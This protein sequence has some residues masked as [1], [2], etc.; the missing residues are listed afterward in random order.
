[1][2]PRL[3]PPVATLLTALIA[4][5]VMAHAQQGNAA[6]KQQSHLDQRISA[7]LKESSLIPVR[8]AKML[9]GDELAARGMLTEA[10]EAYR[11]ALYPLPEKDK[12]IERPLLAKEMF[13]FALLLSRAGLYEEA[14]LIYAQGLRESQ[15]LPMRPEVP[16]E[17]KRFDK[18]LFDAS[19]YVGLGLAIEMGCMVGPGIAE[20][21]E[22]AIKIKPD[23]AKAYYELAC[24][25]AKWADAAQHMPRLGVPE[26]HRQKARK[27]LQQYLLLENGTASP[28]ERSMVQGL[29]Y[30]LSH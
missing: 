4:P 18:N 25:E 13:R 6:K 7:L 14:I 10:V 12:P 20:M 9:Q 23:F 2:K 16:F 15:G 21:F 24:F 22:T 27:A 3:V 8:R 28:Y 30:R 26:P 1:M 29:Q 19:C 5:S 11:D 17:V